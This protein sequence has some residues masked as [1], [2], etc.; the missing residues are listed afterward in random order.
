MRLK[1]AEKDRHSETENWKWT[2]KDC[3][4]ER[5]RRLGEPEVE[6]DTETIQERKVY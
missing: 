4:A 3:N 1:R 6:R 2:C 5:Q